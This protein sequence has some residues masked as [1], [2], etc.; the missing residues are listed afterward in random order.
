MSGVPPVPL[1]ERED[2][3]L[4]LRGIQVSF[5][6]CSCN[7]H[8]HTHTHTHHTTPCRG[9]DVLNHQL[10]VSVTKELQ[11]LNCGV[12]SVSEVGITAVRCD[13]AA[14]DRTV[15]AINLDQHGAVP[16]RHVVP[17]PPHEARALV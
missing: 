12:K 10:D 4:R 2:A 3:L 15:L 1:L 6:P 9:D 16:H 14:D 13:K 17:H 7:T 11:A 8:T 5:G